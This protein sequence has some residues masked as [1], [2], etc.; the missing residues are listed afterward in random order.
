MDIESI[1][2][3]VPSMRGVSVPGISPVTGEEVLPGK[4]RPWSV[5]SMRVALIKANS[6]YRLHEGNQ[7]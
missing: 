6:D 1:F 5:I 4:D 2:D 3:I 7:G